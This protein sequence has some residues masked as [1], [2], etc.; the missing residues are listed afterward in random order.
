MQQN[1]AL[2]QR[3][4]AEFFRASQGKLASYGR[5]LADSYEHGQPLK[6][7]PPYPLDTA[8]LLFSE[9]QK[10]GAPSLSAKQQAAAEAEVLKSHDLTYY[11]FLI[12][13]NW[14][15]RKANIAALSGD[16]SI[17]RQYYGM[18]TDD[19]EDDTQSKAKAA[20]V[21]IGSNV[22]IGE[23]VRVGTKALTNENHTGKEDEK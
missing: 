2:A 11:D 5:D 20:G 13:H 22:R 23:N 15:S 7:E 1:P 3:Y 21:Y 14:W 12:G 9:M 10:R 19:D 16:T 4:S 18:P 8:R 6:L 17:L